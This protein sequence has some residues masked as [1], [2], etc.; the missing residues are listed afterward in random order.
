MR[1]GKLVVIQRG[2]DAVS[3]NGRR[4]VRWD[5]KCDCGKRKLIYSDNLIH[6]RSTSCGCERAR[7]LSEKQTTHGESSTHLYGVWSAMKARCNNPNATHY[8][9]YGGRGI[10]V[11]DEWQRSFDAFREWAVSSGYVQGLSLDRINVDGNYEP[12]NCRWITGVGQ[13]NNRRSNILVTHD[14][15]THTV[16]EWANIIGANPKTIFSRIYSGRTPY[17][18]L[19]CA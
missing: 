12:E 5:C 9:S 13:A 15:Q 19:F 16:T 7:M 1:F 14:G 6:G 2:E 8:D 4:R 18:A 11:C 17:D 10:R 3:S